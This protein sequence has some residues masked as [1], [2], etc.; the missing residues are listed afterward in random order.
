MMPSDQFNGSRHHIPYEQYRAGR[1]TTPRTHPPL[2]YKRT[3]RAYNRFP[4]PMRLWITPQALPWDPT[5]AVRLLAQLHGLGPVSLQV[6][7][8]RQR[9]G[10]AVLVSGGQGPV[11][12]SLLRGAGG[13]TWEVEPESLPCLARS[14]LGFHA[15][16]SRPS[17][18]DW[19]PLRSCE[20]LTSDSLVPLLEA[21]APVDDFDSCT[22][23][24]RIRPAPRARILR[25][26]EQV[27][28]EPFPASLVEAL[29]RLLGRR[30]HYDE[31]TRL[32]R[33]P[34]REGVL[35]PEFQR[36]IEERLSGSLFEVQA[37]VS[38]QG[39]NLSRL[40]AQ[41]K[42]LST[43]FAQLLSAGFGGLQAS[44]WREGTVEWR[45]ARSWN[46][47]QPSVLLSA[48]E[49]AVCWHPPSSELSIP[50]IRFLQRQNPPMPLELRSAQGPT[51]GTLR[52][53]G[54]E[55]A[56]RLS[57]ADLR[58][59][60]LELLG[61]TGQGKSTLAERLA[62]QLVAGTDRPALVIV[63]PHGP[64][65]QDCATRSIPASREAD[66][67]L[68]ELGNTERP[69]SLPFIQRL[70]GVSQEQLIQNTFTLFRLLYRDQWSPTRMEDAVWATTT[71]LYRQ[72][73]ATLLDVPRLLHEPLFRQ[74]AL[75][76][77]HDPVA[78]QFW[79]DYERRS[80]A[81]QREIAQP[82]LV[83]LR[84]LFRSSALRNILCQTDGP[85]L[86]ALLEQGAIM[87]VSLAGQAIQAEADLLAELL[88]AKLHLALLGRTNR[89]RHVYVIC[90]ESQRLHGG[91]LPILLREG[92]KLS[93]TLI[94]ITQHLSGWSE[95]LS[96]SI[97]GNLGSLI[98]FRCGP[99]DSHRLAA[100]L[101]PFK[102]H[103]LQNLDRHEAIAK[104]QVN[105]TTLPA[106]AIRTLP[107]DRP[108]DDA[109]L[110]RLR[111]RSQARFTRPR[112]EVEA[113]I[114]ER[115]GRPMTS[116]RGYK[117]AYDVDEE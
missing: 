59:G 89:Q 1:F 107:I 104:I 105:G 26:F 3:A 116:Q 109:M 91:S 99:T 34:I 74:Q 88:I 9:T 55:H 17:E 86:T 67:V 63:D 44:A 71:T 54:E 80:E 30:P 79:A 60:H 53:R 61:A 117:P 28:Q 64:L 41:A 87:L 4:G 6:T 92:R 14:S 48:S 37:A 52:Q 94:L 32:L 46:S 69:V 20:D 75:A 49:L 72:P 82:I 13:A 93:A 36:L 77:L 38:I 112:Q 101:D 16:L 12:E 114:R 70:P 10:A 33:E 8:S 66:A 108:A 115:L 100:Q 76:T 85:N 113:E 83:R 110:A 95:E 18:P 102:P 106:L 81:A 43:V 40:Q 35:V 21:V 50:G 78:R 27:T 65:V 51:I 15:N 29:A 24:Y 2:P 90:D 19:L 111:E 97:L 22:I 58:F 25:A 62:G 11:V 56:V 96:E 39:M 68:W 31:R 7:V 103:D 73:Q 98:C 47:R 5:P 45:A 42:S 23:T 57:S 84:S